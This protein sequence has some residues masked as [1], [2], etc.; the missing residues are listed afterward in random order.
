VGGEGAGGCRRI[1]IHIGT[2]DTSDP[3]FLLLCRGS[4]SSGMAGLVLGADAETW[5][6]QLLERPEALW[7]LSEVRSCPRPL[8]VPHEKTHRLR[9]HPTLDAST[10]KGRMSCSIKARRPHQLI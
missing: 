10:S 7:V 2:D 9:Y 3:T 4:C 8:P 5:A 6:K 1:F